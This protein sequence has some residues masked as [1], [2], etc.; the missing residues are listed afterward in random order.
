MQFYYKQGKK[1]D[2]IVFNTNL[3]DTTKNNN[4]VIVTKI[5]NK[6]LDIK[7]IIVHTKQK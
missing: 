1:E 3:K 2:R 4:D 5:L 7:K 6:H